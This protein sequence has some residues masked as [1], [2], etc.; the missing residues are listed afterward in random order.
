MDGIG[1]P[2]CKRLSDRELVDRAL[3]ATAPDR[4]RQAM[5]A[6]ADRYLREVSVETARRMGDAEA[7]ADVTQEAFA[8]AFAK[9]MDGEGPSNPDRL[10]G[11]LINFSRN[12]ER[13]HY[14]R[15]GVVRERTVRPD[16]EGSGKDPFGDGVP[17]VGTAR[18]DPAR[19]AQAHRIAGEVAQT[20]APAEQELFR[21]YYQEELTV[22]AITRRLALAGEPV[23]EKTVQNK[24]TRV[25]KA[26]A[27]GFQAYLLVHNDRTLCTRLTAII[28]QYAKGFST[29]LRDHTVKHVRNCA[30]CGSCAKCVTCR[31]KDVL[32]ISECSTAAGCQ[33][34]HV[35]GRENA[36]LQ[37]EWAPAL[38]VVLFAGQIRD[39]VIRALNVAWA[40]AAAVA[41]QSPPPPPPPPAANLPGPPSAGRALRRQGA[42]AAAAAIATAA[43]AVGA[44]VWTRPDA[45][46]LAPA[47]ATMP[48]IAYA[49]DRTVQFRTGSDKSTVVAQVPPGSTVTDLVWS[50]D[51]SRLGWL[52]RPAE[53][54]N[55]TLHLSN[56][57]TGGTQNWECTGCA[58]LAFHNGRLV[59]VK[60]SSTLMAHP[61][62]GGAP[63]PL[64]LEGM[65]FD[66]AESDLDV[67]LLGTTSAGGEL[68][69][70]TIEHNT[71]SDDANRLYRVAANNYVASVV[72]DAITQVPGGDA[73]PGEHAAVNRDGTIL[74]YAGNS[75]GTDTCIPSDTVTVINLDTGKQ[76]TTRLPD[77]PERPLRIN[78]IWIDPQNNVQA[79][80]FAQPGATCSAPATGTDQ[81]TKPAVYSL[82]NGKWTKTP[83]SAVNG[84]AAERGWNA[85][86]AGDVGMN[87]YRAPASRLVATDNKGATVELAD[88]ATA[89]AWAPSG[90]APSPVLGTL[91]G[92]NQ[93]GYGLSKPTMFYNGGSPSGIVRNVKWI[94]WGKTQATGT[95]ESLYV[96][97]D[98][99]VAESPWEPA[100]VVAFDLGDCQGV[101]TYRKIS[102]FHPGHGEKF[103]PTVFIDVCTG[104]YS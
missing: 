47:A 97:G 21:L 49:T 27:V 82:S 81:R 32:K 36:A 93:K 5:E 86:R 12:R 9:L 28:G 45:P 18:D 37:A 78:S 83:Q 95:G 29:A 24:V 87:D 59:T 16:V 76:T 19:L 68:L 91:W 71:G 65:L 39:S 23:G 79:S 53:G 94:S 90:P 54:A 33:S 7:A 103:D 73:A 41:L 89:F 96:T 50:P 66:P 31:V 74:A 100:S 26:L 11:W 101:R 69:V 60:D 38:V 42:K 3:H 98:R 88:A 51:R 34:C 102:S 58:G 48:T 64:K 46:Q 77:S 85:Y 44:M 17:R 22:Q 92:P 30:D 61:L 55:S 62:A 63:A 99:S 104:E 40:A 8:A 10:G 43:V 56:V 14:K 6:I 13:N 80:A 70:F 57:K 67:H 4:R 1:Q 20:L 2:D 25:A 35:C 84:G 72:D 15:Q 75:P 52:A